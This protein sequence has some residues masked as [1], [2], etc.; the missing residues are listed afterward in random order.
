MERPAFLH[1]PQSDPV[2]R[3]PCAVAAGFGVPL[4]SPIDGEPKLGGVNEGLLPIGRFA[5]LCR[6]SV[7]RLRHY[8][9]LG[10]LAPARVD[11]SSGYR[12]YR[13]SQA[14]DALAIGLLRGLD[15][16]LPAIGRVLAGGGT[17]GGDA[18]R[19]VRDRM[20]ADLD[21]RRLALAALDRVLAEGLPRPDVA[22]AD[23]PARRVRAVRD[24]ATPET[25]GAV[26][27]ACVARLLSAAPPAGGAGGSGAGGPVVIGVFPLDLPDGFVV[28]AAV[29]DP[30][31]DDVLPGGT[32]AAAVH[33]GPY[34]QVALTAH[35]VLAWCAEHGHTPAGPVRE[36]YLDD[37]A[38][39]SP[40]ALTTRIMIELEDPR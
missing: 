28:G 23:E 8:D 2:A 20:E 22:V 13:P 14:R 15:V 17:G 39:T 35:A 16:P 19:E 40:D 10:L 9:E 11:P 25:I 37:P 21:R 30:A 7:K 38:R 36:L 18:L 24:A 6:L 1:G 34:D 3:T 31:G 33:V 29:E 27:S 5:R 32:F 4:D 26:T 12:Y